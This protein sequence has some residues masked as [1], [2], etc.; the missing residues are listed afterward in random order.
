MFVPEA[1]SAKTSRSVAFRA[2]LSS[3]L[4]AV[5]TGIVIKFDQVDLNLGNA[6]QGTSGIFTAPENGTYLFSMVIG[7]PAGNPGA[8]F[9]R[10]NGV[11]MAYAI[12][13]HT[14][15]WNIGGVTT[16]AALITGDQV[17]VTGEGHVAGAYPTARYHTS[18]S[19]VLVHAS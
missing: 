19:G 3:N 17:W 10:K 2:H 13:G 18:F 9:M 6:Y 5:T 4:G 15:G 8:F 12:A 11:G 16:V 7:N 14:T 1:I